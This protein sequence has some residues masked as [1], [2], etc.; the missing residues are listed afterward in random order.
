MDETR[1]LTALLTRAAEPPGG[2]LIV[3]GPQLVGR[4]RRRTRARR[5]AAVGSVVVSALVVVAA[6]AALSGTPKTPLVGGHPTP[7]S[8]TGPN[9]AEIA[10]G[11]WSFLP[12]API[13]GRQ[14]P[15][16]A[17]TGTQMLVWGGSA[18]GSDHLYS[19]GASF[20][21]AASRWRL[22]P[23][24]PLGPRT[25]AASVWTGSEWFI[26][27]GY[28]DESGSTPHSA[29]TG[30]LYD[31]STAAWRSV[32]RSPLSARVD[33]HALWTGRQV[34]VVGGWSPSTVGSGATFLEL[35]AYDPSTDRWTTLPSI[36]ARQGK[37]QPYR[38]NATLVGGR[39]E[40]WVGWAY[41]ETHGNT[42]TSTGGVYTSG[43]D[44]VA[45]SW[46]APVVWTHFLSSPIS[47]G[48]GVLMA[49][50]DFRP[51]PYAHG[52]GPQFNLRGGQLDLRNGAWRQISHGPVDDSRPQSVW[53]GRALLSFNG[54]TQKGS[55]L[56]GDA[57]VWDPATDRWFSL[58]KAPRAGEGD[59]L[60][61]VWTGQE[62][63]V[64]GEMYKQSDLS[65]AGPVPIAAVGLR[66][67][68]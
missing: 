38:V 66:L 14:D 43:F 64:W 53:T 50:E 36:P 3:S 11:H 37:G 57:A 10:N 5:M 51:N 28:D 23:R 40:V 29:S 26:W 62:L 7:P 21:P 47:T 20:D 27:G 35:A 31:P 45:Q 68:R 8:Q 34:L 17:W 6:S 44:L 41:S 2:P 13:A 18:Q 24:S 33:A 4:A 52:P 67:G 63:I 25:R 12:P 16:T 32:S 1:G 39:L 56:P 46:T 48:D 49:A 60:A 9:A 65:V 15:A 42:G 22:L 19:D 61:A 54:S 30:A 58:P 59:Q 55:Q